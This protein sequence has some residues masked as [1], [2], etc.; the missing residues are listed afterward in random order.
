MSVVNNQ[1]RC[2][3]KEQIESS[4]YT[5]PLLDKNNKLV[6]FKVYGI[7]TITYGTETVDISR[8][9][10]MF[11]RV[12]GEEVQRPRGAMDL[13]IGFNYAKF[14]PRRMQTVNNLVLMENGFGKCIAGCYI[15]LK[16]TQQLVEIM[17][18]YVYTHGQIASSNLKKWESDAFQNVGI[19][20]V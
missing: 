2:G 17:H 8:V 20:V 9:L 14:H 3:Q 13:L 1:S 11:K 15:E 6:N 7:E 18:R 19:V 4:L 5:L 10:H 12:K 16:E